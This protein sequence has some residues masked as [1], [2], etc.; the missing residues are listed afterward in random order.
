MA[1]LIPCL[2]LQVYSEGDILLG[3]YSVPLE[4]DANLIQQV[5]WAGGLNGGGLGRL[6]GGSD[7]PQSLSPAAD[8]V[9]MSFA[10]LGIAL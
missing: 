2:V 10:G 5:A 8:N 4:Y 7:G 1:P 9:C 6:G 3:A